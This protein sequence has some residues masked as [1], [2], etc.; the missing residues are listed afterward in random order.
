MAWPA[1]LSAER[2]K[3]QEDFKTWMSKPLSR[4]SV[5]GPAPSIISSGRCVGQVNKQVMC[6]INSLSNLF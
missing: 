5:G 6:V 2:E 4:S 1:G 3:S